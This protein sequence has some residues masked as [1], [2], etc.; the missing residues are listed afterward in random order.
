MKPRGRDVQPGATLPRFGPKQASAAP[1]AEQLVER[2]APVPAADRSPRSARLPARCSAA[3]IFAP[4]CSLASRRA[5]ASDAGPARSLS[6]HRTRGLCTPRRPVGDAQ[7]ASAADALLAVRKEGR[8]DRGGCQGRVAFRR[9]RTDRG[10]R[11]GV[12]Y[13][14]SDTTHSGRHRAPPCGPSTSPLAIC[15]SGHPPAPSIVCR[16]ESCE[17]RSSNYLGCAGLLSSSVQ[18]TI[19]TIHC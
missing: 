16:G 10:A 12:E 7:G 5:R 18:R 6:T 19:R 8:R 9:A 15:N 13:W 4:V 2:V 14:R 3:P 11:S 17:K 1:Q